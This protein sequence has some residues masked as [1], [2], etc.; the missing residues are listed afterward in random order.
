MLQKIRHFILK[1]IHGYITFE[2]DDSKMLTKLS[3][4][5]LANFMVVL[6]LPRQ[7][8]GDLKTEMFE[9]EARMSVLVC[10]HMVGPDTGAAHSG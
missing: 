1:K 10:E 6:P 9:I 8:C 4:S 5:H 2:L 7:L 3:H